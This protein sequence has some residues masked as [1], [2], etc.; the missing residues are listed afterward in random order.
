LEGIPV[1]SV[2]RTLLDLAEVV[3]LQRLERAFEEADRLR[4]LDLRAIDD[5]I[6]R[7]PGRHGLK[8][9]RALLHSVHPVTETRSE[10]E[11]RFVAFCRDA[12]LP[13]PSVNAIVE[14]F[15]VDAIWTD[16][17]LVIELDSYEF[18][19]TRA[20][21]ERD[22]ARDAALQ[23]AGYRVLRLTWRRLSE[24]PEAVAATIRRLLT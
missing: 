11:R 1:T 4:L 17:R 16:R 9:L 6:S 21:F 24:E 3:D 5:T 10:L 14:G 2:A 15:E 8:T 13:P 19:H 7:N 22:R 20:A 18:H 12:G 23:L